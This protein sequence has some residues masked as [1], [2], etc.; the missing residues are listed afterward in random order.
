MNEP[1]LVGVSPDFYAEAQGKFEPIL[2]ANLDP[3]RGVRY[4]P[5]PPL[6]DNHPTPDILNHYDAIF[7]LATKI[8]RES[9]AGVTRL[10]LVARWGVGYNNIDPEALTE[11][12]IALAITP[13]AVRGPVAEAILA[14]LFALAKNMFLQDRLVR[15]GKWRGDLPKLGINL[16]GRTLGS[17]GCGNIARAMFRRASSL[18][19]ARFL[20]YDPYVRQQEVTELGVELADLDIVCGESDFLTINT[21]LNHQTRSLIGER[22]LRLMKSS[23]FLI[24][25]ARGPIVQHEAL[26]KALR[27][28]W[29]AGAG[30]D[31]FHT[32]PLPPGDPLRELDNVIL[33][34]HALAWT[35]ELMRDNA[36]EACRNLLAMTRGQV[37]IENIVNRE[38]LNRPGF[39]RKLENWRARYETQPA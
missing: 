29:I 37:I 10:A 39:L 3:V 15:E 26:V 8:D 32:E 1:I 35:E 5:M 18:G 33:A 34:P 14:F 30:L 21:L 4:C 13:R 36:Q 38:V 9:V 12:D 2:A 19:F 27:E 20:A 23:A 7:A 16:E 17:I 22:E 25:T 28:R 31:V 11:Q 6:V 24:N